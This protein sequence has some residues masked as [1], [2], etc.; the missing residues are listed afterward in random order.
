MTARLMADG[1]T[2][3]QPNDIV[4]SELIDRRE[5]IQ[6][7][8]NWKSRVLHRL[9]STNEGMP[10]NGTTDVDMKLLESLDRALTAL[11]HLSTPTGPNW[12]EREEEAAVRDAARNRDASCP[13][14]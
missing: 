5:K 14:G 11:D 10:P 6:R 13:R 12:R 9:D 3:D 4:T 8:E 1:L 2:F 7:L